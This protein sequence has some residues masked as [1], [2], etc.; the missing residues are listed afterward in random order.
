[1]LNH[2]GTHGP[3]KCGTCHEVN[4]DGVPSHIEDGLLYNGQPIVNDYDAA[5]SWMHTFTAEADG[6]GDYCLNCHQDNSSDISLTNRTWTEHSSKGRSSR[7]MMDK[8][9]QSQLGVVAGDPADGLVDPTN[10]V[11]TSCHGD[12]SGSLSRKGCSTKWRNH[13]IEGRA[14]EAAWEY[15]STENAG[16]TCG[17]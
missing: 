2:D 8:A 16:S 1:M 6:L 9:E 11:C 14:S 10:T 13:L 15:M 12:R 17:W 5:V 4:G 3:L 7:E